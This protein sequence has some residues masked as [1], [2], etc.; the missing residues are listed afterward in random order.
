MKDEGTLGEWLDELP[1]EVA[2]A[3]NHPA[4]LFMYVALTYIF[5]SLFCIHARL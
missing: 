2:A 4:A 1:F 3:T 5:F